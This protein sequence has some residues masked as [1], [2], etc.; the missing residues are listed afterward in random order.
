MFMVGNTKNYSFSFIPIQPFHMFQPT[1]A[2]HVAPCLKR[3]IELTAKLT[4]RYLLR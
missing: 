1:T 2:G 3:I 4:I